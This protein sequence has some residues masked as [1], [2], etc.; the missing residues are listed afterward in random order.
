M[1]SHLAP[2]RRRGPFRAQATAQGLLDTFVRAAFAV[3]YERHALEADIDFGSPQQPPRPVRASFVSC[4][5]PNAAIAAITG[6]DPV[7]AIQAAN[8]R[9]IELLDHAIIDLQNTRNAIIAGAAPA[10]AVSD[11]MRA[12]LNDRFH[13]NANDRSVWNGRAE[14]STFVIVRRLR[15]ARQILADGFMRYVCLGRANINFTFGGINCAGQGCVGDTRAATCDGV[16][17]LVLCAP[18]WTDGLDDQAATLLH[19]CFHIYF[20]FIGDDGN[21]ANAHCYEQLTMTL[22]GLPVQAGFADACP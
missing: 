3:E 8:T 19:E 2:A 18:W 9:A 11:V 12:A 13:L 5:P 7:G 6:P 14:G 22:N 4:N 16:S 1:M 21:F 15:G 17:Q 20:G 10:T